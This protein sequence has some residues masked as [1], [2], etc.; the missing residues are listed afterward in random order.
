MPTFTQKENGQQ[1]G[2]VRKCESL[3]PKALQQPPTLDA[4]QKQQKNKGETVC[5][6]V[7]DTELERWVLIKMG[8]QKSKKHCPS[9]FNQ[10]LKNLR[11]NSV[12]NLTITFSLKTMNNYDNGGFDP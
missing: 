12:Q 8:L 10:K 1:P 9:N 7:K 6:K 5:Q 2:Q 4:Q 11:K 3:G